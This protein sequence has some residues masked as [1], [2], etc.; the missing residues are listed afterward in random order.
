MS[1]EPPWEP[2]L[3]GSDVDHLAGTLERLRATFRWKAD[4]LD[5]DQLWARPVPSSELSVGGLLKHLAVVEEQ[6][7]LRGVVTLA[8]VLRLVVPADH[9]EPGAAGASRDRDARTG[10][11]D[12]SV[13][14]SA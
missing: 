2:P 14:A 9:G 6:G 8:D 3:A 10:A 4:G 11:C 1:T 13:T 12:P 7:A 5:V